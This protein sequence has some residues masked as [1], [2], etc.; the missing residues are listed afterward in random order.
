[1][2]Q[3]AVNKI[4]KETGH[5]RGRTELRTIIARK[6]DGGVARFANLAFD[7]PLYGNTERYF[8]DYI[9]ISGI[10]EYICLH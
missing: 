2:V 6:P 10:R 1:M 7:P 9:P 8:M 3:S 5:V 4:D